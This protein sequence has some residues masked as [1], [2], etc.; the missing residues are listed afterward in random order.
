MAEKQAAIPVKEPAYKL[1]CKQFSLN[2]SL[3][4]DSRQDLHQA[5]FKLRAERLEARSSRNRLQSPPLHREETCNGVSKTTKRL[6]L[7]K[8]PEPV[9]TKSRIRNVSGRR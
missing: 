7:V 6:I 9:R 8:L 3:L 2:R 4:Q 1:L 5:L